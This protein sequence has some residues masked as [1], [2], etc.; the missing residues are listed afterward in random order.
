VGTYVKDTGS[1]P[2]G[3]KFP[4]PVSGYRISSPFGWR[5]ST[6]SYH[7]GI[8]LA[9]PIGTPIYAADSGTVA[10]SGNASGYGLVVYIN[11]SGGYQTRYGHCSRLVVKAGDTVKKGQL[12]AYSGN[13]GKSSGPHCHFEIRVN[14]NAV[15]PK[16]YQ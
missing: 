4:Y 5:E 3:R 11:H 16:K 10:F 8:D 1:N 15:D 2:G 7:K 13:T 9:V 14:G 6:Q 12:I